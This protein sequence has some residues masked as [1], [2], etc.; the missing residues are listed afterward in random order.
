MNSRNWQT[1]THLYTWVERRNAGLMPRSRE[2][3]ATYTTAPLVRWKILKISEK[4]PLFPGI[5]PVASGS[6]AQR[7]NH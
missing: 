6:A 3:A 1:G 5:E 2:L 7:V 4:C